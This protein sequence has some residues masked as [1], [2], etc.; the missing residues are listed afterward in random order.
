MVQTRILQPTN[1]V[2]VIKF[3]LACINNKRE[4]EIL[5][6]SG[7]YSLKLKTRIA[8]KQGS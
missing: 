6:L 2:Y 1:H 3:W 4:H 8:Y 7:S 5:T